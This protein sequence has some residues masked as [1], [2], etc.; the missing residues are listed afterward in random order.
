M[1]GEGEEEDDD[2]ASR[3]RLAALRDGRRRSWSAARVDGTFGAT[4]TRTR[5]GWGCGDAGGGGRRRETPRARAAER[6]ARDAEAR[7]A[8]ARE[9]EKERERAK[10][11]VR[12][13]RERLNIVMVASECAPFSKTGGL[14]DVVQ[15]LP[16]R[17]RR[18]VIASWWSCRGTE[19]TRRCTTRTCA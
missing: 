12:E 2:A 9:A 19:S 4:T 7:E 17:S 3:A 13:C 8:E 1:D 16:K 15:S 5:G 11:E 10:V 18:E 14:G 6:E